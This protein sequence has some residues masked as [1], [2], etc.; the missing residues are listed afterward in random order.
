MGER[1]FSKSRGLSTSVSFLSLPLPPTFSFFVPTLFL[2]RPETGN[3]FSLAGNAC[4]AGYVTSAQLCW[5]CLC[6]GSWLGCVHCWPCGWSSREG[7]GLWGLPLAFPGVPDLTLQR[8]SLT[9]DGIYIQCTMTTFG[10]CYNDFV[11]NNNSWYTTMIL[12]VNQSKC[13]CLLPGVVC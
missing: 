10:Q 2:T 12:G 1:K 6:G 9:T 13:I 7:L 4:Y 11:L 5:G 3:S 8:M